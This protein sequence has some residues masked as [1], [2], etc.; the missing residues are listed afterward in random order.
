MEVPGTQRPPEA[1]VSPGWRGHGSAAPQMAHLSCDSWALG[2]V[3]RGPGLGAARVG[4]GWVRELG[5][6]RTAC[7][8]GSWRPEWPWWGEAGRADISPGPSLGMGQ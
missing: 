4:W 6:L 8:L 7:S 1:R 5:G 3:C 2:C